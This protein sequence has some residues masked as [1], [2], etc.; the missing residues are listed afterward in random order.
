VRCSLPL[1]SLI[2][3]DRPTI[4][5]GADICN[6]LHTWIVVSLLL[7]MAGHASLYA[8]MPP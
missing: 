5:A 1:F 8:Y 3:M 2:S 4:R 6:P 7:L